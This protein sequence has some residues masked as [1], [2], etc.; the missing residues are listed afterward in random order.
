MANSTSK[1]WP[2]SAVVVGNQNLSLKT[3][4]I[5]HPKTAKN[6]EVVDGNQNLK[7]KNMPNST[8]KNCPYYCNS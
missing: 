1:N 3:C 7:F 4:Q 8:P 6:S 5:Q 2:N